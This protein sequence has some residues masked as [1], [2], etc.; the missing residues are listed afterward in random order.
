LFLSSVE[1]LPD[2]ERNPH[3]F[4]A[5]IGFFSNL[6]C[7]SQKLKT[8]PHVHGVVP[9]GGL[10]LDHTRRVR[11]RE[12]CFFLKGVLREVF[13]GKFVGALK[14]TEARRNPCC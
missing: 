5:E 11:S 12:N 9:A 10:L 1:T 7:W 3:R 2:V 14:P 13:R 8:H 4:G 6:H